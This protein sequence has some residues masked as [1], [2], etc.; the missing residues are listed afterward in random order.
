MMRRRPAPIAERMAISL[1]LPAARASSRLAT[2]THAMRS[3]RCVNVANLLL[4]RAAGEAQGD[5]HPLRHRRRPPPHRPPVADREPPARLWGGG[6]GLLLSRWC[7]RSPRGFEPRAPA[8]RGEGPASTCRC[9]SSRSAVSLFT[10]IVFGLVPALRGIAGG[11][12]ASRCERRAGA[13]SGSSPRPPS[14]RRS[15]SSP[16]SASRSC[17]WSAPG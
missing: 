16:R 4:V 1:C 9:W 6:L 17:C 13:T 10:G 11:A 15:S 14:A 12:W 7:R 3:R 8:R 5:R 2:F